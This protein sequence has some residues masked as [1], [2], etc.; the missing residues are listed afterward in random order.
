M[1]YCYFL[2]AMIASVVPQITP[3]MPIFTHNAS[4][5]KVYRMGLPE[6]RSK[7]PS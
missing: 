4:S 6:W 2:L 5:K 3:E 1:K 7:M